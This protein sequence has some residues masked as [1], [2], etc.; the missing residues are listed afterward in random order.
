MFGIGIE[1]LIILILIAVNGLLAMSEL[2]VVS[3]QRARLQRRAEEG[4]TGAQ[5]ALAL[6]GEPTRFLSTVQ[7]GIT[8][9]GILAG[10]FGGASIASRLSDWFVDA[11]I[12]GGVADTLSVVLVVLVITY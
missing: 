8:L 5:T 6:A 9:V 10:A 2:A 7:I 3:A 11:G 4:D 1:V 12:S